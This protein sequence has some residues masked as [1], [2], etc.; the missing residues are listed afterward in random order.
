MSYVRNNIECNFVCNV[1][2]VV[3]RNDDSVSMHVFDNHI[4]CS[5]GM[6]TLC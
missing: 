6:T 4:T 3:P 2:A 1:M 5:E